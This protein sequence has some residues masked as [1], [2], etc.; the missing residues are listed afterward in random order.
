M[1]RVLDKTA[2]A[3]RTHRSGAPTPV[4]RSGGYV[5]TIGQMGDLVELG[6]SL[7]IDELT[8]GVVDVAADLLRAVKGQ[9]EDALPVRAFATTMCRTVAH[10]VELE[11]ARAALNDEAAV[12]PEANAELMFQARSAWRR[13]QAALGSATMLGDS[14]RVRYA[15]GDKGFD[16]SA[17][18]FVLLGYR[19]PI[20]VALTMLEP[21]RAED[22]DGL[23]RLRAGARQ[24]SA[25]A[26]IHL[27]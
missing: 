1:Q 21:P 15:A 4:C 8:T 7:D 16:A 19:D 24:A 10:L 2:A 12:V 14:L 11:R 5:R 20:A 13:T 6:H 25:P 9:G 17:A 22:G 23:G 3:A 26:L 27:P 18:L